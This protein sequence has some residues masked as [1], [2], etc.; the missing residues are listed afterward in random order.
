MEVKVR[1]YKDKVLPKV[2]VEETQWEIYDE[3]IALNQNIL[4]SL[5][6]NWEYTID[7]FRLYIQ[8]E[9]DRNLS[10]DSDTYNNN[11]FIHRMK[12]NA[13][14]IIERALLKVY[15]SLTLSIKNDTPKPYKD[16]IS[17]ISLQLFEE[18]DNAV[19]SHIAYAK[20]HNKTPR[21]VII[22][23]IK[24][25]ILPLKNINIDKKYIEDYIT[26][27]MELSVLWKT[28]RQKWLKKVR[29]HDAMIKMKQENCYEIIKNFTDQQIQSL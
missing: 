7:D 19:Q 1:Y 2:F 26:F 18:I 29:I 27:R 15:N 25:K 8:S 23:H 11:L 21:V 10:N 12:E 4:K 24:E 3:H 28:I 16:M 5:T 20:E 22:K 17:G 13:Y 14:H 9:L 6:K